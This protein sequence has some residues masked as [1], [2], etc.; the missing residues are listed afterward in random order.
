MRFC[1]FLIGCFIDL[2]IIRRRLIPLTALVVP[3]P[4]KSTKVVFPVSAGH[5]Q[6]TSFL[7]AAKQQAAAIIGGGKAGWGLVFSG[8]GV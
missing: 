7:N 5:C 3:L 1:C 8:L 6:P 4:H 2:R